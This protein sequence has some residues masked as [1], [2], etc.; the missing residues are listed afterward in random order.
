MKGNYW[1]YGRSF[2]MKRATGRFGNGRVFSDIITEGLGIKKT[3]PAY[4]KLFNSPS[5]LRTGVCFASGGAGVDPVTSRMLD[6]Y[7]QGARKFAVM[8]VIPL[9]CLPLA[10]IFLGGFVISCNFF[11]NRVAQ[12]YNRK[13]SNGIQSWGSEFRGAKFVYVDMYTTLTDVVKNYRRYGFTNNKNG[14]CCMPTAI[15]PCP[16]PDRYVFYD[17]AHPSEKAYKIPTGRFGN[18]RVFT[19]TVAEGLGIKRLVPAYRRVRNMKPDEL[20]TGVCFAS[21]GSGLDDLTSAT[22][23]LYDLGARKFAVMGVLPLGCMPVHRIAF[24]GVF[25]WCNFAFNKVAEDFNTKLQKS[26]QSYEVELCFKGAK[27]AYVD[28]YGTLMDLINHPKAYGT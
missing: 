10:R 26:L 2:N 28:I 20:K 15:I 4:R 17:F 8:G 24:G 18:G 16:F 9:G 7:D 3:L 22:L 1:P 14:C 12:D 11:A 23:D 6:L 27:F 13:L 19:D 5:D 21:G 25:A